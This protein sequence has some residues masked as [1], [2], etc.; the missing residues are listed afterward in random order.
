MIPARAVAQAFVLR[1]MMKGEAMARP[2]DVYVPAAHRGPVLVWKDEGHTGPVWFYESRE[3]LNAYFGQ[4][5][6]FGAP[7][8]PGVAALGW[9]TRAAARREATARGA[10]FVN[11]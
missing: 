2:S 9:M 6:P 7:E 1:H 3:I 11:V 8:P 4:A 5:R 10:A